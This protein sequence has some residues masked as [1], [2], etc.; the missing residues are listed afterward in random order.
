[1]Q[2]TWLTEGMAISPEGTAA[3]DVLEISRLRDE[4]GVLTVYVDAD[5]RE[6]AAERPGW[7]VAAENGLNEIR[8]QVKA[9]GD[10]ARWTAVFHRLD[11]LEPELVS[12]LDPRRPGRGRALFATV[13]GSEV[14]T[15]VLHMPLTNRV[16]LD[17]VAHLTPLVTALDRGRPAGLLTV[18]LS[19]VRALEQRLGLVGV[20][21]TISLE[22]DTS[23]WRQMKGPAAA[24]PAM[25][26]HAAPQH[27]RFERRL[28][29]HRLRALESAVGA[30]G[31]LATRRGWDRIVI[32][33]DK[34]LA[35]RLVESFARDGVDVTL[36]DR[37]LHP[38][39]PAEVGESL[40]AELE[41]ANARREAALVA[42]ARDAAL[43]GNAGALGLADTLTALNEGRV[44][45]L[46]F[47]GQREYEGARTPDGFLVPQGV[48]PPGF[49]PD[50]LVP[51]PALT[52]HMVER[53]LAIDARVTPL[54]AEGA[55][56]LAD[57][58][59]IAALLRW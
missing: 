43:S 49:E 13:A 51:E 34:R 16:A 39:T 15:V 31:E 27:D 40:A 4:H 12:L 25:A 33:G 37:T 26:Q 17:D 2:L 19:E 53:A 48:V 1:M 59:G 36:V 3:V 41:K 6:Q 57:H 22:P 38:L 5:P 10:R 18:S 54:S 24:N 52:G 55:G 30:L 29:E 56:A 21:T 47:D 14:H 35:D 23:E 46:L 45:R 32:A 58:E 42:R 11:E 28:D 44:G 8:E 9:E 7:V 50:E 20:V